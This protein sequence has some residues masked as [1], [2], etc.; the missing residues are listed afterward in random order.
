MSRRKIIVA[1]TLFMGGLRLT[2]SAQAHNSNSICG[3]GSQVIIDA[4]QTTTRNFLFSAQRF[5]NGRVFGAGFSTF[6][7]QTGSIRHS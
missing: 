7:G 5:S 4:Q 3:L 1:L 6:V 2:G